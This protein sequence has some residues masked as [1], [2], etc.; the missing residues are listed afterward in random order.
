MTTARTLKTIIPGSEDLAPGHDLARHRHLQPYAIVLIRG[1]FDQAG[2]AG[3]V[4]VHAGDLLIQPTLDAHANRMPGGRGAT[5]LRLPWGDIDDLGGVFELPDPDAVIRAAERDVREAAAAA[6]AQWQRS[7]RRRPGNDLPDRLAAEIVD[8][9]V[10]SLAGWSAV[11]GVARETVARAFSAAFGVSARRFRAEL[12]ARA[13]WLRIVRTRDRLAEI[14]AASG[15]ADQ[16]HM[17]RAI[18]ELTGASP[19][20]WRR[21]PRTCGF[22]RSPTIGA[23]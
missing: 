21:D 15:F 2:Y 3:R 6:R 1:R 14:A 4:R 5:L 7:P 13:A 18:R 22:S 11:L 8:E 16:A 9:R 17:T 23:T 12:R 19:A 10:G 20:A